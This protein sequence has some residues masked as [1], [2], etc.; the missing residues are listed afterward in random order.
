MDENES[1]LGK[2]KNVESGKEMRKL[3]IAGGFDSDCIDSNEDMGD[4]SVKQTLQLDTQSQEDDTSKE[5]DLDSPELNDEV[6]SV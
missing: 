3:D 5:D 2:K 6:E 4:K 1:A